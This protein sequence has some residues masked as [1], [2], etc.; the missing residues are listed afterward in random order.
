L[1]LAISFGRSVLAW[2]A[3][4]AK[5]RLESGLLADL[6]RKEWPIIHEL[7]QLTGHRN[8]IRLARFSHD[9]RSLATAST[10]GTVRLHAP[11]VRAGACS[12]SDAAPAPW[13]QLRVMLCTPLEAH[14]AAGMPRRRKV[15]GTPSVN[16]V[17][18]L[19]SLCARS[20][21][22]SAQVAQHAQHSNNSQPCQTSVTSGPHGLH[23]IQ[24][25]CNIML[26]P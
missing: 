18:L 24:V 15:P 14:V 11:S 2:C 19:R 5:A 6:P 17:P 10:D 3:V 25:P 21:C 7:C 4:T 22:T 1:N 9:G 16:Q 20:R 8:N 26:G 13:T 23:Y 12:S